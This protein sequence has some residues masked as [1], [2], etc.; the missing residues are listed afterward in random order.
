[1]T[2]FVSVIIPCR[3]EARFLGACLDSILRSDY[4]PSAWKSWLRTAGAEDGTRALIEQYAARDTRVRHIDNPER[5]TPVALNRAILAA[6]GEIV[7]RLDAH[8]TIAPDYIPLAVDYLESS[9]ADSVGG[10]MRTLP[11]DSGPF[12]EPIRV[13][14]AHR[15]GVG[16][17]HFRTGTGAPRWVDTVFGG[18]WRREIFDR[19]GLFNEK[20][21]RSQDLEF[22]LRLHRAGGKILLAPRME[23]RYY[24][25]ATLAR[26]WRHNWINGVWA[27][28]PFA[29]VSGVPVRWRHMVPMAFVAAL[30]GTALTRGG[31]S[32]RRA[33]STF[34]SRGIARGG[35]K[36]AQPQTCSAAAG[37]FRQPSPGVWS[38]QSVGRDSS[39][40][41]QV[42]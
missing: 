34:E 35:L 4:P 41:D 18:C 31:G 32:H 28:L 6:R 38:R 25:R 14:L 21:E 22:S 23:T 1:M 2:P 13:A 40:G 15:F 12:A 33:L 42:C 39:G 7:M 3:N 37:G 11:Q 10:S 5:I 8:A 16:N 29:Y 27:V 9:G 20:L 19:V 26:F 30:I 24:A 17:S 36:G